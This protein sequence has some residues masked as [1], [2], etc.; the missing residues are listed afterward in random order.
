MPGL[1]NQINRMTKDILESCFTKHRPAYECGCELFYLRNTEMVYVLQLVPGQ[2]PLGEHVS[3]FSSHSF[4][5]L[6]NQ[7]FSPTN[8]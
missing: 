6:V 3:I 2:V 5:C 1:I 8:S 7:L 4:K